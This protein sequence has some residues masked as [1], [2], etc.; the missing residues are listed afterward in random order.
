MARGLWK[1]NH[2]THMC[3]FFNT[4]WRLPVFFFTSFWNIALG[5]CPFSHKGKVRH[6]CWV[7]WPVVQSTFQFIPVVISRVEVRALCKPLEFFCSN[8]SKPCLHDL[9]CAHGHCHDG[10]CLGLLHPL[11]WHCNVME[12]ET[13]YTVVCFHPVLTMGERSTY[14]W[15]GDGQVSTIFGSYS[16][17]QIN[18]HN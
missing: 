3:Y 8:L 14:G 10:T 9:L 18:R 6:W 12:Q 11:S 13:F 2:H 4:P 15:S 7:R 17:C 1:L 5:I 16:K